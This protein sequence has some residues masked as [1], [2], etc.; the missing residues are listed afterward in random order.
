MPIAI[1]TSNGQVTISVEVR[2]RLSIEPG[3]RVEF[4]PQ[5]DGT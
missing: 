3:T 1:A 2:E 5:S 4:V